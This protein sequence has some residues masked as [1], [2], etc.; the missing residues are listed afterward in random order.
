MKYENLRAKNTKNHDRITNRCKRL[1]HFA[2]IQVFICGQN[3]LCQAI[4]QVKGYL[5]MPELEEYPD[6]RTYLI[7]IVG[8]ECRCLEKI[9]LP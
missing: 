6:L 9:V 2:K 5:A 7:V 4:E 1:G 8:E 3:A